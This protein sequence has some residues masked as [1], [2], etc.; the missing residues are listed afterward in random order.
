MRLLMR[1]LRRNSS[2]EEEWPAAEAGASQDDVS[3]EE[4]H[5]A[6]D[7]AEDLPLERAFVPGSC[8]DCGAP[9][10]GS[11]QVCT[12]CRLLLQQRHFAW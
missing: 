7:E 1:I 2:D 3:H 10:N 11:S 9:S 8:V 12:G 4:T 6:C 5:E